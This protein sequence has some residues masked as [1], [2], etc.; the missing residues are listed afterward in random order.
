MFDTRTRAARPFIYQPEFVPH[1]GVPPVSVAPDGERFVV[2]ASDRQHDGLALSVIARDAEKSYGLAIDPT[3]MRYA[4]DKEIGPAWVAHHFAWETTAEGD[5]LHERAGFVPLPHHGWLE[6]GKIGE[7]QSYTLRPGSQPLRA[8]IVELLTAAGGQPVTGDATSYKQVVR[9][10]GREIGIGL[11]EMPSYVMVTMD[12]AQGDPVFMA[13]LARGLD[14]NFA[15][16]R[17]DHLF[18]EPTPPTTP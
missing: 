10:D 9:I 1:G 11:G 16:G 17:F 12:A 18:I 4:D 15:T 14:A 3:R 13:Q 7:F 2:L 8:A 5:T 6:L